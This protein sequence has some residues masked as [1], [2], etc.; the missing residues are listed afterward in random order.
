MNP[1]ELPLRD[2]HLPEPIGWWPPAPGWWFAAVLLLGVVLVAIALWRRRTARRRSTVFIAHGELQALQDAWREH[3]DAHRL[4]SEVSIW[5][6]R[7]SMSLRTR[8]QA[9]SLTGRQWWQ[10]L[11]ELAG[12]PVFGPD[13]G[14]LIGEAPYRAAADADD[15]T[16]ALSLCER[17]LNALSEAKQVVVPS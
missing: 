11:D 8:K 12:T 13:G 4:I 5:L 16:R 14:Q 9:A 6:R 1:D 15:A 17:W 3:G 2:I 7:V 10:Y